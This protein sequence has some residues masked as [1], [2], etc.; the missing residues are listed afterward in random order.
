M[1]LLSFLPLLSLSIGMHKQFASPQH[2]IGVYRTLMH[3]CFV[4]VYKLLQ[5]Y[6][7]RLLCIEVTSWLQ[8]LSTYYA[9]AYIH[10]VGMPL[11]YSINL[12]MPHSL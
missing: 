6:C 3:A 4:I 8:Y 1:I 7:Q 12:C 5:E 9:Y 10:T 2:S 11:N